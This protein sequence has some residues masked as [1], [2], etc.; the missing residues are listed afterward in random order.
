MKKIL[1]VVLALGLAFYG[2]AQ[3]AKDSTKT[4]I[5]SLRSLTS[6]SSE[7]LI[8]ID[9]NKQYIRGAA[10]LSQ[11]DPS[12]IESMNILK[13]STAVIKYGP[14]GIAGAIEIKTKGG[15]IGTY[16][17]PLDSNR[18][19]IFGKVQGLSIHPKPSSGVVKRNLLQIDTDPKAKPMYIVDGKTVTSIETLN[20]NSIESVSVFKDASTKSEYG[21]K[22]AGGVVII[23][24]KGAKKKPSKNN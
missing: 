13:D 8:V 7:P 22:A 6:S 2:K 15:L 14:D 17:K 3:T 11:F 18:V 23:T 12:N 20:P 1:T 19:K 16:N 5:I 24:T 21:E 10:S 9:G 4:P